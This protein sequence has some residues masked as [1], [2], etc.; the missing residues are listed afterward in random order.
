MQDK[1]LLS[2]SGVFLVIVRNIFLYSCVY[3]HEMYEYMYIFPVSFL[4]Y[5]VE[6][7]FG[8]RTLNEGKRLHT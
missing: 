5:Y 2:Q 8:L 4:Q 3:K 6:D 1:Y 7:S